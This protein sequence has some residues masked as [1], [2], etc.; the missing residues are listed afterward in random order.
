MDN[1]KK[2]NKDFKD[3][4]REEL[5]KDLEEEKEYGKQKIAFGRDYAKEGQFDY[6]L[7]DA[8]LETVSY[9]PDNAD[10]EG[11]I[12][13]W[14]ALNVRNERGIQEVMLVF[15]DTSG[16]SSSA[17]FDSSSVLNNSVNDITPNRKTAALAAF[18]GVHDVIHRNSR[19][20]DDVLTLIQ[21]FDLD[22]APRGK[23]SPS[24]LFQTAYQAFENPVSDT[25]PVSTSLIPM[26]GC[27][28]ATI[29]ELLRRRPRQEEARSQWDKIV[30][31]GNQLKRN[32]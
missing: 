19:K 21:R 4:R 28:Q 14:K 32:I 7:A 18:G 13:N 23:K 24:E 3:P 29:D 10:W 2:E 8:M 6:D 17:A 25:N 12:S 1:N 9:I 11:L 15:S 5:K 16:S 26:R 30:S 31:I 22:K 27:L 20:E